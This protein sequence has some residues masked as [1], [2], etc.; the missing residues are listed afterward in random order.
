MQVSGYFLYEGNNSVGGELVLR[1]RSNV[2][3]YQQPTSDILSTYAAECDA[4]PNC[5]AFT[6]FG[7]LLGNL[8][9]READFLSGICCRVTS[10]FIAEKTDT[11]WVR[12]VWICN[13][14]GRWLMSC[15]SYVGGLSQNACPGFDCRVP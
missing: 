4:I 11:I 9:V 2:P 7:V 5:V 12:A 3:V 13:V 10:N 8:Q 6:S 14:N 15:H 1:H